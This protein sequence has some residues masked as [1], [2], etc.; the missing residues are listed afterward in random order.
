MKAE[1]HYS[2]ATLIILEHPTTEEVENVASE[3]SARHLT[4]FSYEDRH[5][6]HTEERDGFLFLALPYPKE[7]G[8]SGGGNI[9]EIVFALKDNTVILLTKSFS[10]PKDALENIHPDNGFE[11]IYSLLTELYDDLLSTLTAL[12]KKLDQAE[13]DIYIGREK[14]MVRT[15]SDIGRDL[16]DIKKSVQHHDDILTA[17]AHEGQ[18]LFPDQFSATAHKHVLDKHRRLM[19]F[20]DDNKDT[21]FELRRTNDSLL[22]TKQNEV[23]K[24]LTIMAF[25]TFPLT[26]IAGI[27]GMNTATLPFVGTSGDFWIIL[28]IMLGL[29]VLFFWY[30][31]HKNWL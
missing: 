3:H 16:L 20:L 13:Q 10:I 31:K 19:R 11:L 2:G 24:T 12:G 26:L 6:I 21:A 5:R 30:F 15:L 22:S 23:M 4:L 7:L 28:G 1:R 25:V 17:F 9:E 27:F 8:R 18:T 29:A 14:E